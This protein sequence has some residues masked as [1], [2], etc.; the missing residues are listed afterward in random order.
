MSRLIKKN[1]IIFNLIVLTVAIRFG[2]DKTD[3]LIEIA[4]NLVRFVTHINGLAGEHSHCFFFNLFFLSVKPSAP[5]I[6]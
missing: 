2:L 3:I 5:E 6:K 1:A 4:D